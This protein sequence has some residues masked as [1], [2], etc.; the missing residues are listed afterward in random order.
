MTL[1]RTFLYIIPLSILIVS[2]GSRKATKK[3]SIT[4]KPIVAEAKE[5]EK[6]TELKR[7]GNYDFYTVNIADVAKKYSLIQAQPSR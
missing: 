1:K 4:P 2:C 5:P 7:Q 3:T 6:K